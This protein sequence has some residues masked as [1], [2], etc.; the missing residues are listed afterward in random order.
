M[1]LKAKR[2]GL[3]L[4]LGGDAVVIADAPVSAGR[5]RLSSWT[6][7]RMQGMDGVQQ[8]RTAAGGLWVSGLTM[9]RTGS[10]MLQMMWK[11][12][13]HV[14]FPLTGEEPRAESSVYTT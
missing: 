4:S 10:T 14:G 9:R 8:L 5:D 3:M 1:H 6:V 13:T 7:G 2:T 12:Y 11:R